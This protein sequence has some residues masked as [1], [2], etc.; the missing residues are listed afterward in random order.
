MPSIPSARASA[1]SSLKGP[2]RLI[3]WGH[4]YTKE[5]TGP[6]PIARIADMMEFY[7]PE[8][9]VLEDPR[10]EGSRRG[11]YARRIIKA[12]AR[13][14]EGWGARVKHY[15]RGQIRAAFEAEDAFTKEEIATA[16]AVRFPELKPQLPPHRKVWMSED[17]RMAIFDAASLAL[18]SMRVRQ[19]ASKK[20]SS[21][22]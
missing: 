9:L 22:A 8:V 14:A 15:S 17:H 11:R 20:A 4:A 5:G 2:D 3:D 6:G 10:G 19:R 13:Y 12:A 16:I 1:G 18:T 21:V 7:E